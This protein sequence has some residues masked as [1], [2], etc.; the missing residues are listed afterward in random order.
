MKPAVAI[1]IVGL[2]TTITSLLAWPHIH[3]AYV[4]STGEY[5]RDA[6]FCDMSRNV[7]LLRGDPFAGTDCDALVKRKYGL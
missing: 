2:L 7:G 6:R 4:R 3:G 1:A 5:Q